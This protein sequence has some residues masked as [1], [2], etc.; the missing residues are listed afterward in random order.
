MLLLP[1]LLCTAIA[2]ICTRCA[3]P[4]RYHKAAAGTKLVRF[5][6]VQN[7]RLPVNS[8][9]RHMLSSYACIDITGRHN[10]EAF[11]ACL[12]YRQGHVPG[13]LD[14][15]DVTCNCDLYEMQLSCSHHSSSSRQNIITTTWKDPQ[16]LYSPAM[17]SDL[18][19]S[20]TVH[21]IQPAAALMASLNPMNDRAC[22][23]K[24]SYV[25]S[26]VSA[27]PGKQTLIPH[28]SAHNLSS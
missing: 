2:L 11:V 19:H 13:T 4:L 18:V 24:V 16:V 25:Q 23:R 26:A 12:V 3:A 28:H 9:Q 6:R 7:G 10:H 15:M 8:C 20:L 27:H 14:I 21:H 5:C 17:P 22:P 1:Q